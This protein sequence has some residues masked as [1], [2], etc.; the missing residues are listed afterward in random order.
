VPATGSALS[1]QEGLFGISVFHSSLRLCVNPKV[2]APGVDRPCRQGEVLSVK[3]DWSF[4]YQ[5]VKNTVPQTTCE[6]RR[7]EWEQNA[8]LAK[9]GLVLMGRGVRNREVSPAASMDGST[10]SRNVSTNSRR[11]SGR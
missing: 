2:V 3:R 1:R 9:W 11:S 8:N 6:C 7:G 5:S 10:A 4:A